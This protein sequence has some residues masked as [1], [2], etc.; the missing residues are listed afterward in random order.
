GPAALEALLQ[1]A[2]AGEPFPL[3]LIDVQMPGM[4]GYML[5]ERIRQHPEVAGATLLVLTSSS[6][7]GD[8][9]RR[10]ELG[11]SA[12]LSKPIKQA[13]LW[14]AIMQA[15]G[16]P[17]SADARA[18]PPAGQSGRQTR[19]L[20][21]LLAE[22]N[23]VN[24]KLAVRLL[25]RRGHQVVVANNGREALELLKLQPFDV[26]L[27]DV[28]MPELDGHEATRAIRKEEQKTGGHIP[29]IA[30]TAYAM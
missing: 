21:V 16:M 27:M 14:K 1:A 28:Q 18:E 3:V 30:M 19:R 25:E 13:D 6:S 12:S 7:T 8:A 9:A 24:Q 4:D 2:R 10:Q 26:I 29:I 23:L 15:L 20:R 5:A 22:D 17:L 11:I